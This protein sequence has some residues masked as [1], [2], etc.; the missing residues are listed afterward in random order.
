MSGLQLGFVTEG[1]CDKTLYTVFNVV[2][3]FLKKS[4][5]V[6]IVALNASSAFDKINIY[7]LM[8][9]L[10]KRNVPFDVIRTLLSWYTYSIACVKLS[11]YYSECISIKSGVK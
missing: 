10:I 7:G 3:Y 1:G 8:T 2:N 9:K 6:F 4:S 11:K 5:D